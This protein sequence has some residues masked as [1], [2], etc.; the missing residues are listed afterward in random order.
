[1]LFSPSLSFFFN[2][3]APLRPLHSFPTRRSSDLYDLP[4]SPRASRSIGGKM[5]D[6]GCTRARLLAEIETTK[7]TGEP[8]S[9]ITDP[10]VA[11]AETH[12]RVWGRGRKDLFPLLKIALCE[13][14]ASVPRPQLIRDLLMPLKNALG[15][16]FKHGN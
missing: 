7:S 3:S 6:L 16:A 1:M 11:T 13:R 12:V 10:R 2:C 9:D 4:T 5:I 15:N 14:F 8:L